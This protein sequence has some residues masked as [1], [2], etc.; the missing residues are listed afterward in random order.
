MS[1]D[2][3]PTQ[4]FPRLLLNAQPSTYHL[5]ETAISGCLKWDSRIAEM[6]HSRMSPCKSCIIASPTCLTMPAR[7]LRLWSNMS[8]GRVIEGSL[9]E[10]GL[11]V[12]GSPISYPRSLSLAGLWNKRSAMIIEHPHMPTHTPLLVRHKQKGA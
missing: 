5:A 10:D 12:C 9:R 11:S 1:L 4:T 7:I 2:I 6:P 8:A 3:S